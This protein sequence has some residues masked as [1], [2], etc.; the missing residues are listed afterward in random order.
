MS[1]LPKKEFERQEWQRCLGRIDNIL[2]TISD[3]DLRILLTAVDK[4]S[5]KRSRKAFQELKDSHFRN[6]YGKIIKNGMK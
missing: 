6:R 2:E 1:L 4:I 5:I 3:Q